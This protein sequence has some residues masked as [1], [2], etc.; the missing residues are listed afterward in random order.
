M[1]IVE[2]EKPN[3]FLLIVGLIHLIGA[4]GL[5]AISSYINWPMWIIAAAFAG[6]LLVFTVVYSI[7][8]KTDMVVPTL[9]RIP[10]SLLPFVLSMFIVVLALV[11]VGWTKDI[12]N[13]LNSTDFKAYSYGLSGGLVANLINN[14]PMSVLYTSLLDATNIDGIYSSIAASNI[15]A[16]I[17]P[18]GALAGIMFVSLVNK[19]D[20]K[21]TFFDFTKYGLIIGL[22]TLVLTI[23]AIQFIHY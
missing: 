18:L 12:A 14:I 23:T 17:T 9:K 4:T 7:I 1:Q 22:P 6:S 21:F 3:K 13:A 16:Y 19:Y 2:A 8:K 20:I 15:A 5:L 10:W 11:N